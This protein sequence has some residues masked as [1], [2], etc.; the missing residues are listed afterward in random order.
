MDLSTYKYNSITLKNAENIFKNTTYARMLKPLRE[1]NEHHIM[2]V[3]THY[4]WEKE[5]QKARY[6]YK[7]HTFIVTYTCGRYTMYTFDMSS[8]ISG[9]TAI[10]YCTDESKKRFFNPKFVKKQVAPM[11]WQSDHFLGKLTNNLVNGGYKHIN[12][13]DY[14][15]LTPLFI[16]RTLD[17]LTMKELNQWRVLNVKPP[18]RELDAEYFPTQIPLGE[19]NMFGTAQQVIPRQID[20]IQSAP[21]TETIL[22]SDTPPILKRQYATA[23]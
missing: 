22:E 19:F 7:V 5:H 20:V 15:Q 3:T 6:I 13:R 16:S 12:I 21:K 1:N 18:N 14:F 2:C 10:F 4:K 9:M 17:T 8:K 11:E 23:Y